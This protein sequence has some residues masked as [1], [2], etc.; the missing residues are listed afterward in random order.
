MH[1]QKYALVCYKKYL[2]EQKSKIDQKI[3]NIK[4]KIKK[5]KKTTTQ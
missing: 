2:N 5:T 3:E 4:I 1:N